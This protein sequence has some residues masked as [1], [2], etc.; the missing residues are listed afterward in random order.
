MVPNRIVELKVNL[1]FDD[2]EKSRLISSIEE[3]QWVAIRQV[4]LEDI[5]TVT[6][7]LTDEKVSSD[8]GKLAH[9]A[10]QLAEARNILGLLS[11][12]RTAGSRIKKDEES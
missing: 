8:A 4:I 7:V 12:C 9:W 6:L 2:S 10:G 3:K 1:I 11:D 5:E